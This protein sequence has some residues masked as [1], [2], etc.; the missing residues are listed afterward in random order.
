MLSILENFGNDILG[1]P[2]DSSIRFA[3]D[4][5]S[6]FQKNQDPMVEFEYNASLE[7][8]SIQNFSNVF[9]GEHLFTYKKL[10][11]INHSYDNILHGIVHYF[12]QN[13]TSQV[14]RLL[15]ISRKET[16]VLF[17]YEKIEGETL[18]ELIQE[19]ID[20][21]LFARYCQQMCDFLHRFQEDC[22]F[23]HYDFSSNNIMINFDSKM[24]VIDFEYSYFEFQEM[25]IFNKLEF[26][27][28]N[29]YS[30]DYVFNFWKIHESYLTTSV[31][32]FYFVLSTLYCL[33]DNGSHPEL[34]EILETHFMI[35][36]SR[37]LARESYTATLHEKYA[38]YMFAYEPHTFAQKC[39]L[40]EVSLHTFLSRFTPM[41]AFLIFEAIIKLK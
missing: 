6:I 27:F 40:S 39:N 5:Y 20:V 2:N 29:E 22:K 1:L 9:F 37:N 11:D 21:K 18:T 17:T 13:Q 28:S 36:D 4:T 34:C 3:R 41:N 14:P 35:F 10:F 12:F 25:K 24:F 32:L 16:D 30:K 33:Y 15:S 26:N 8:F 31:D 23:I 19:G 7:I 38:P